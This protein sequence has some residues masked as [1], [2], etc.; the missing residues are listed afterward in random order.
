MRRLALPLLL[1]SLTGCAEL[2]PLLVEAAKTASPAPGASAAPT[3][4]ASGP[5]GPAA[6]AAR[7]SAAASAVAAGDRVRE[8][9]GT[10][11]GKKAAKYDAAV[12]KVTLDGETVVP[13]KVY[14]G[15]R[16]ETSL[17]I[18]M[19]LTWGRYTVLFVMITFYPPEIEKALGEAILQA[20]PTLLIN[21]SLGVQ[22]PDA[23][24]P[25]YAKDRVAVT[26]EDGR[27]RGTLGAK[28]VDWD[29]FDNRLP[30]VDVEVTFDMPLPARE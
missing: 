25:G 21:P 9:L 2:A 20:Q 4:G 15:W 5:T 28:L 7:P 8:P 16:P 29:T 14:A 18:Q 19:P 27:L 13:T 23:D 10:I 17:D 30:A 12:A 26:R 1:L 24:A 3:P 6:P 11:D 22:G